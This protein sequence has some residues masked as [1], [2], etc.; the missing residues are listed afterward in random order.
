MPAPESDRQSTRERLLTAGLRLFAEQGYANVGVGD[1]E[2]AVGLV[3]RRGALYRHFPSKEALLQAAVRRY[4]D[5]E[6]QA[7]QQFDS[8]DG[9][10]TEQATQ[11]GRRILQE[12]DAQHHITRILEREGHR[13]PELREQFRTRV[14]EQGYA[15]VAAILRSWIENVTRSGAP[16]P[17]AVSSFDP[18]A[19]AVLLTGALVNVRRSTWTFNHPPG[20][21][22][23]DSLI[24][25]WAR[26]CVAAV[27][28]AR[29][30]E[31]VSDS[32]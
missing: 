5:S 29:G 13:L 15:I 10:L 4:I 18:D 21:L 12:M 20:G 27:T 19:T 6:E 31:L 14:S 16:E 28:S 30:T 23:D 25:S 22:D 7:R 26:L 2:E 24:E 17:E 32:S 3:P 8:P 1:V 11:L 9:D